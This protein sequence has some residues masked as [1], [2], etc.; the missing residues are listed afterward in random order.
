MTERI[1]DFATPRKC[2]VC[3]KSAD[4]WN[5]KPNKLGGTD[6]STRDPR[7]EEHKETT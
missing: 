3:Q 5:F 6:R 4:Y 7:C 2:S 1:P